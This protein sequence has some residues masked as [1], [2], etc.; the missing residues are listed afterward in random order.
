M[1]DPIS[2][3]LVYDISKLTAALGAL[4]ECQSMEWNGLQVK[5]D[6]IYIGKITRIKRDLLIVIEEKLEALNK[7][8]DVIKDVGSDTSD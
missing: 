2:D 1:S 7:S 5:D 3:S 6:E 8:I 4:D